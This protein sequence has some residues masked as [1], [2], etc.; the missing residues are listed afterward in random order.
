[1]GAPAGLGAPVGLSAPAD[2]GAP[3]GLSAPADLGAPV[4]LSAPT[5][6][7]APVGL[8][9]PAGLLAEGSGLAATGLTFAAPV[10]G[11]M[12]GLVVAAL[13]FW[14]R[15]TVLRLGGATGSIGSVLKAKMGEGEIVIA[16]RAFDLF[17]CHLQ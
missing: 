14:L 16:H 9:A 11:F 8:G 3:V 10:L 15:F 2:L 7:G 1:L 13:A 5:G 17:K 6:L 12:L 4:G